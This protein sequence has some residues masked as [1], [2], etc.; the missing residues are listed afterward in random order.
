P[1]LSA[2]L[3]GDRR[4]GFIG[5]ARF[6][7]RCAAYRRR[8][9]AVPRCGLFGAGAAAPRQCGSR[10]EPRV[11]VGARHR[12]RTRGSRRVWAIGYRNGYP[13]RRR[14]GTGTGLPARLRA[15][16][17]ASHPPRRKFPRT[18]RIGSPRSGAGLAAERTRPMTL[19]IFGTHR[20]LVAILRG[21]RPD[22][23]DAA[24]D[25]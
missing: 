9:S 6:R 18:V 23:A 15:Y 1:F 25:A 24:L 4:E 14:A 22:E 16:R 21:I 17:A 13:C 20:S 12:R 11:S 5:L 3:G 8:R 10:A 19:S 7:P 2:P